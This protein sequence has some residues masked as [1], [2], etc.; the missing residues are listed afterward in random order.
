[1]NSSMH[2]C[3]QIPNVNCA[4]AVFSRVQTC[5][6]QSHKPPLR[7]W[8][9]PRPSHQTCRRSNVAPPDPQFA[10][11]RLASNTASAAHQIWSSWKMPRVLCPGS[12]PYQWHPSP[13]GNP[14]RRFGI[15][16][17][18]RCV[19]GA[20]APPLPPPRRPFGGAIIRRWHKHCP[21]K[22]PQS[23]CVWACGT[24]FLR[25]CIPV[26]KNDRG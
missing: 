4:T 14:H 8:A 22:N 13:P 5:G 7:P 25:Q 1:M 23:H 15:I 17:P 11:A 19:Y 21:P 9:P 3:C 2:S 6:F 16:Q 18:V 24:F 20:T 26:L 10:P 12:A